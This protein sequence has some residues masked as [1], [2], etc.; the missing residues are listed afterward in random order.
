MT[1]ALVLT[2]TQ[3]RELRSH[4]ASS[5]SR[6][7]FAVLLV[8]QRRA[9]DRI[10]LYCHRVIPYAADGELLD[11]SRGIELTPQGI[12]TMFNA[13]TRAGTGLVEVHSHPGADKSV[14][15]SWMDEAGHAD[16]VDYAFSSLASRTVYGSVVAGRCSMAG[17]IW[18]RHG[19]K[20]VRIDTFLRA[21]DGHNP[22][23]DTQAQHRDYSEK[24]YTRQLSVIGPRGQQRMNEVSVGIVGLGGTGSIVA[25]TLA[26][27]GVR[28]FVLVDHDTVAASNLNRLDG[29]TPWDA[30]LRRKK[31][32]VAR[33][34]IHR[35][36]PDARVTAVPLS[37][38]TTR[39]IEELTNVDVLIGCTDND[40]TRLCLNEISAAYL[41]PYIDLGSGIFADNGKVTEAG[42]RVTVVIPGEGCLLCANAVDVRTGGHELAEPGLR[43]FAIEQGYVS[44]DTVPSPA[45][46][47][48]NQTVASIAVT[49]FKALVAGLRQPIRQAFYD[50]LG[51]KVS[52][53]RFSA[54][55]HCIVCHDYV[56]KADS[57]GIATRYASGH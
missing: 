2:A 53:C 12:V 19:P 52:P 24:R 34:E 43:E 16:I 44:G 29:G 54:S 36:A 22:F 42:G 4:L 17:Q 3:W 50:L 11:N 21:D 1:G 25:R 48:L 45:V 37:L 14:S 46:M 49:E 57:V 23:G 28:S 15:F 27:E 40:G 10:T 8:G 39:A 5:E 47:S 18:L 32:R 7:Q 6:E 51:G 35:I 13:A 41:K 38:Y 26:Y 55:D 20:P 9:G 30:R 31:V 56:G 33:R